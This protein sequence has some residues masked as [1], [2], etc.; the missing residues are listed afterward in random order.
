MAGPGVPTKETH[1]LRC[2][3]CGERAQFSETLWGKSH[4]APRGERYGSF[5][6]AAT[7]PGRF[8]LEAG[9]AS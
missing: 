7:A 5:C 1:H 3:A 2:D 6:Y 4:Q 9:V 8:L